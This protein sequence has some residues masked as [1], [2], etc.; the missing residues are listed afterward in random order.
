MAES[1]EV[2]ELR[3][4]AIGVK[5]PDI[6]QKG[7]D[8]VIIEIYDGV[9][10]TREQAELLAQRSL[11]EF[12]EQTNIKDAQ[13]NVIG[14]KWVPATAVINGET[15]ILNSGYFKGNTYVTRNNTI[16]EILLIFEWT[17]EGA[18]IC[19]EVTTRL[20]NKPLGIFEGSGEDA[21]PLL[22]DDGQAIAPI[23]NAVIEDKGEITGL[24]LKEAT[25]LS[26][27]LNAGR[28][29]IQFAVIE[30]SKADAIKP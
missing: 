24:N 9:N 16:G 30:Y 11:L 4:Q 10:V 27:Q 22:D 6:Q 8:E 28:L 23:V 1:I 29:P 7:V 19:R 20:V 17:A 12:R 18:Q 14:Q 3:L 2:I 21:Q 26:K 15:K 13:G 25:E 5:N